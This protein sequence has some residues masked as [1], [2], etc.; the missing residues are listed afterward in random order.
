MWFWILPLLYCLFIYLINNFILS[1]LLKYLLFLIV[2]TFISCKKNKECPV[3][4]GYLPPR[5]LFI[6]LKQGGKRLPDSVLNNLKLSYIQNS[7]KLYISDFYRVSDNWYS[8]GIMVTREIGLKSGDSNIKNYYIE[9]PNG[10]MDTVYVDYRHLT[11]CEADTSACNCLYPIYAVKF[12]GI[13]APLDTTLI[14]EP[15]YLFNK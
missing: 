3:F 15:V 8:L 13:F 12:N 2:L 11:Q 5:S 6:E 7:T 1:L 4:W 14:D 9:Y 10:T